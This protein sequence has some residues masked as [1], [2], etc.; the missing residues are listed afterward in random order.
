MKAV[1]LDSDT[2]GRDVDLAPL[3][4]LVDELT[5]WPLTP[6]AQVVSRLEGATL[7]IVNKVVI[8]DRIMAALPDLEMIA[9]TATGTNNVD[10]ESA[11]RRGIRVTNVK[12]Y[13]TESVAQ[14][15]LMIL[16]ALASRLPLH[17]QRLKTGHW[18][19]APFFCLLDSPPLQLAGKRL[20]IVG[21]GTLGRAVASLAE[22]FGMQVSFS[23]RPGGDTDDT[24]APLA[25]LLPQADVVSLH[26]PL[27]PDTHHLIGQEA[28]SKMKP[29]ALL[30]NCA[31]GSVI[32][33]AAALEALEAGRLGG[34]GVDVLPV[35]PPHNGHPLLE[36]LRQ[37][38]LNLIVTPH[39]AWATLEA[40]QRVVDM[41]A[42]NLRDFLT[43]HRPR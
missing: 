36:A 10:M 38:R 28:L 20:V 4:S 19:E 42:D 12:G 11:R 29:S 15:T 35:E 34:L 1:M 40:R 13:G 3:E 22:A 8:D 18:E 21:Q 37:A 9:V 6:P 39:N 30:I 16:L 31:R 24:R 32:D 27:T 43:T 17:Q 23:A 26:C 25:E 2:L 5:R 7:A 41:T 33:E 14:H